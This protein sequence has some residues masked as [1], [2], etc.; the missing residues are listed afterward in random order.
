M[1]LEGEIFFMH[2]S[3]VTNTVQREG[4]ETVQLYIRQKMPHLPK[5]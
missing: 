3:D 5:W 1:K 4:K 2:D